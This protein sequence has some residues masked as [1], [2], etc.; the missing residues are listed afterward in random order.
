LLICNF[1]RHRLQPKIR[2]LMKKQQCDGFWL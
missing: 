2:A 1:V